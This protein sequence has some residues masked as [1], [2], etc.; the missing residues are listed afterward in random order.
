M[1]W[2]G[3]QRLEL[4]LTCLGLQRLELELTWLGLQRLELESS[5]QRLESSLQR[6]QLEL[7]ELLQLEP[8]AGV[9]GPYHGSLR[10]PS[11]A[12]LRYRPAL[13]LAA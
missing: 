7:L 1:T 12:V 11:S 4:E 6:L 5:L 8:G 10:R 3:L 9:C 13:A 2:L